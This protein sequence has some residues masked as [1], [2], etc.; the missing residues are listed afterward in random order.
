MT[1]DGCQPVGA[2]LTVIARPP[3]TLINMRHHSLRLGDTRWYILREVRA[4]VRLCCPPLHTLYRGLSRPRE[5]HRRWMVVQGGPNY[6]A[7][8]CVFSI[9]ASTTS[10][11]ALERVVVWY[12][13]RAL[14][15]VVN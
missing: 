11:T 4:L 5:H 7:T 15:T 8:L 9:L 12:S 3:T 13:E 1:R 10:T 14:D 2:I 6:D